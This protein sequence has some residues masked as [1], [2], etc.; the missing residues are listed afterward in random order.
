MRRHGLRLQRP[1]YADE[2]VIAVPDGVILE[3][4]LAHEW[5]IGVEGYRSGLIELLVAESPD[6]GC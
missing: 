2:V 1:S 5:G 6:G 4:E 3:H